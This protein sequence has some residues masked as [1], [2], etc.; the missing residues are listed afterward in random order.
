MKSKFTTFILILVMIILVGGVG[1]LGY[2]ICSDLMGE[3][4]IYKISNYINEESEES[5]KN[6]NYNENIYS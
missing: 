5:E 2:A 1:T 6:I 4:I 3:D